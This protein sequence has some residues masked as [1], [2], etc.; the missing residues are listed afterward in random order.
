[1]K[2]IF[3][4]FL[5][6]L[7]AFPSWALDIDFN[8][9]TFFTKDR[10]DRV[11]FDENGGFEQQL[12]NPYGSL[13]IGSTLVGVWT[14]NE[15]DKKLCMT[16]AQFS[17]GRHCFTVERYEFENRPT[18]IHAFGSDGQ[19]HFIWRHARE[20][21][22]LLNPFGMA[23]L[24]LATQDRN[25]RNSIIVD[26]M[27]TNYFTGKVIESDNII[28]YAIDPKTAIT[29]QKNANGAVSGGMQTLWGVSSLKTT[30]MNSDTFDPIYSFI[31]TLGTEFRDEKPRQIYWYRSEDQF[32]IEGE[33][34]T[35][36]PFAEFDR[37]EIFTPFLVEN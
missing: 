34:F 12:Q 13:P 6:I 24:G 20:G 10:L 9:K 5:L 26:N 30:M 32:T 1:M 23:A 16:Y 29:L 8:N 28:S 2:T 19:T 18:E 22:W 31:M 4:A 27:I 14:F 35:I 17:I 25:I 36:T 11:Y 37:K 7:T 15:A 21:D 33:D 3:F